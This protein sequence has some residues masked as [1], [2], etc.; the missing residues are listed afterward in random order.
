MGKHSTDAQKIE[1]LT[2]LQYVL[3]RKATNKSALSPTAGKD[4]KARVGDLE[5]NKCTEA[6]LPPPT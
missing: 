1:F 2:Y 4:L 6:G 5:I 3:Y